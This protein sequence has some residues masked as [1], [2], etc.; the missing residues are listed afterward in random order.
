MVVLDFC[1]IA[2]L[3]VMSV[4]D[5]VIKNKKFQSLKHEIVNI[6]QSLLPSA[7][8]NFHKLEE[9]VLFLRSCRH[10]V[11]HTG[12][13]LKLRAMVEF[14]ARLDEMSVTFFMLGLLLAS[15]S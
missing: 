14:K 7:L 2:Q 11:V 8:A 9:N 4:Y 6:C 1:C 3:N 5:G 12:T 10:Q 13:A 15:H